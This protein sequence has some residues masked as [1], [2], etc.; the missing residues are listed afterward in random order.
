[1]ECRSNYERANIRCDHVYEQT[2]ASEFVDVFDQ[3]KVNYHELGKEQPHGA[4]DKRGNY[5][6]LSFLRG[7]LYGR[8]TAHKGNQQ[9]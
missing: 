1:M 7:R 3:P 4:Y 2:E 8:K 6:A 5:A 9:I